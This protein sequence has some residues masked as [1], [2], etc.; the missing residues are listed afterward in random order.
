MKTNPIRRLS[1]AILFESLLLTQLVGQA[2]PRQGTSA[3]VRKADQS[4][5][6]S[7]IFISGEESVRED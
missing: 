6:E 2:P 7:D 4:L 1:A 3:P 5:I